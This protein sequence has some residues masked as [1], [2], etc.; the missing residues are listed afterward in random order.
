[1]AWRFQ[2][3]LCQ[4]HNLIWNVVI[5]YDAGADGRWAPSISLTNRERPPG[6]DLLGPC[7]LLSGGVAECLRHVAN[8]RPWPI[9]DHV[10]NLGGVATPIAADTSWITSSRRSESKSTSMSGSSS[11]VA[12]RKRS[13]GSLNVRG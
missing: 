2:Q 1:M 5:Q 9:A 4:F 7:I 6:V 12:D 10:C 13:K 3:L 8:R 11:R